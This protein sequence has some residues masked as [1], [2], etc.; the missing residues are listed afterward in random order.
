MSSVE[1]LNCK[2]SPEGVLGVQKSAQADL[3]ASTLGCKD[4]RY[5]D[6]DHN[7]KIKSFQNAVKT[8]I[9]KTSKQP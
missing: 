4:K 7:S 2:S 5:N 9:S 8:V 1:T 6:S 3:S